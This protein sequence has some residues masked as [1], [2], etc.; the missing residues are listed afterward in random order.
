MINKLPIT[1][2]IQD[3]KEEL[4]DNNRLVLQAPPGAGKTTTVPIELIDESWLN[5]KKIIILEPRRIAARNAAFWMSKTLNEKVG[6]R[7]GYSVH[8]DKKVS[9]NTIIEVVTEGVF[10]NRLIK[11]PELSDVA[12]V[13]FDEF[14]ERSLDAD[15]SLALVKESQEILRDDLKILVMSATLDS[16]P[17][18]DYLGNCSILTSEGKS[19]SVELNYIDSGQSDLIKSTVSAVIDSINEDSGSILVFLPGVGEIKRAEELLNSKLPNHIGLYPLYGALSR[20]NQERAIEP[21]KE[22]ERKVVLASSIAES[23]ITIKGI[24]VV[25]DTGLI[26]KPLFNPKT[27]M[28]SLETLNISKA[29]ADQRMGRAG[30]TEPGKCY[31]LWSEYKKLEAF[32]DPG[33]ITE[34]LTKLVLT[35]FKWGYKNIEDLSWLTSPNRAI[36]NSSKDLLFKLGAI[37]EKGITPKGDELLKLPLHPRLGNMVAE[38]QKLGAKAAA[39]DIAAI[40]SERDILQY[41]RENHQSDILYR[42]EALHGKGIIGAKLNRTSYKRV[43]EHSKSLYRGDSSRQDLVSLLLM[44]AYPDRVA[45]RVEPG[46]FQLVNGSDV[47]IPETDSLYYSEFLVVPS[48]GGL[49]KSLRVFLASAVSRDEILFLF[50]NKLEFKENLTFNNDRNKFS[51]KRELRLGYIILKEENVSSISNDK[52]IEAL[53][54]YL[55]REGLQSLNWSKDTVKFR[56]RINYIHKHKSNYPDFSDEA[57]RSDLDWLTTYLGGISIKSSLKDIPLLEALKGFFNYEELKEIDIMA[58]THIKV[59]SGSKIPV[60]YSTGEAILKVRLQELFGLT[61]T[62]K[63][64]GATPLTIHLL[65]PASRPIQIT[66]DLK[67]FWDNTYLE[68]KKDLK[69]RYPKHHWPDDPYKATPTNRVKRKN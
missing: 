11:D 39:A 16:E 69:G 57:L 21:V 64:L 14:H 17:I 30:R 4:R 41:D 10:V 58:P 29:S 67:S 43:K 25:I 65:S 37:D 49:G 59:P 36:F 60:D 28:D 31:R 5:G 20:E 27:G 56:D 38:G 12:L 19:Y 26:R 50:N 46:R 18:A 34:D 45:K 2:I 54:S 52:F 6:N 8:L 13:I 44:L 24:R 42:L 7:V 3:I 53:S 32:S 66:R 61:E 63:V 40:L 23:S 33:I 9:E 15:L 68:V 51:C 35:L 47:I 1:E 22:G 55:K 62:P 48:L